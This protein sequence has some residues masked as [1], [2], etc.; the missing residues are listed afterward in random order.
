MNLK[1][2]GCLAKVIGTAVSLGGAFLMA[3][4]KGPVVN[5]AG[6]SASHVGQPEN[7][8]DPSGSHWLIGA[9][10]LLIGCAG[11]SAF[12][13]LQV[14]LSTHREL[15]EYQ[16]IKQSPIYIHVTDKK[17]NYCLK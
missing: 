3:L 15:V 2:L 14:S 1:E 4:Y 17:N 10:F 5:I 7:V 6:S 12:Y 11:F 8:N 9:C 13:I 16:I